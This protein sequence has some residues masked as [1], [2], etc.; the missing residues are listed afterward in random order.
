MVLN[1]WC[2]CF[3]W[4]DH[5]GSTLYLFVMV[6]ILLSTLVL[7]DSGSTSPHWL[8]RHGISNDLHANDHMALWSNVIEKSK[9]AAASSK[10]MVCVREKW[11]WECCYWCSRCRDA[12]TEWRRHQENS[13]FDWKCLMPLESAWD[14]LKLF[15]SLSS[16]SMW[17]NVWDA[18]SDLMPLDTAW[19]CLRTFKLH[20]A[21]SI[22]KSV[23]LMG[24]TTSF[25]I[26][27]VS[28]N[29]PYYPYYHCHWL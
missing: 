8:Q 17:L 7:A 6:V 1:P 2:A 27:H 11:I 25:N 28:H 12:R 9:A 3:D 29:Y 14:S 23:F 26:I 20:Q 16:H 15:K 13:F 18:L 5:R 24:K 21:F 19:K 10:N 22:K 4:H